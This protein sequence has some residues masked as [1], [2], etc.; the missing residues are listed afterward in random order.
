MTGASVPLIL[1]ETF[2]IAP[3]PAAVSIVGFAR[4]L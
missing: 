3:V 1:H 2:L 4:I